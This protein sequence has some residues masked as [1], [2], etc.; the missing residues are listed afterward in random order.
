MEL[1][2]DKVANLSGWKAYKI[3][4]TSD[5]VNVENCLCCKGKLKVI[6]KNKTESTD[7]KIDI[8]C[9]MNCGFT[10]Y[11]NKPSH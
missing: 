3:L 1:K 7:T 5:F 4:D 6:I 2:I 11:I 10:T 8:G 9:C